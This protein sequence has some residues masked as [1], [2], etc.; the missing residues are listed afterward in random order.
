MV[1]QD[2]KENKNQNQNQNPGSGGG[3]STGGPGAPSTSSTGIQPS[4]QPPTAPKPPTPPA[5]KDTVEVPKNLLQE[6]IDNQKIQDE[7]IKNLEGENERLVYAADKARLS[8]FD[9]RQGIDII[10]KFHIGTWMYEGKARLIVGW[11]MVKDEV[12]TVFEDGRRRIVEDQVIM[13]LLDNGDK[14]SI[15]VEVA[16]PTFANEMKRVTG[17]VVS[18]AKRGKD[19][20]R[21]LKLEDGREI[22]MNIKFVNP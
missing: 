4:T 14:E 13:L 8:I 18:S 9:S 16:Y 3:G 19:E 6:I 17:D 15:E 22:E 7:K 1:K 12:T 10:R 11:F 20:Y 2:N 21:T 5:K